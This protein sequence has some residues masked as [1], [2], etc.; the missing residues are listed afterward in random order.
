MPKI[1]KV[2]NKKIKLN[3]YSMLAYKNILKTIFWPRRMGS[4][5]PP[6]YQFLSQ[7]YNFLPENIG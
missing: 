5:L 1:V 4:K 6:F 3:N 7:I 2:I